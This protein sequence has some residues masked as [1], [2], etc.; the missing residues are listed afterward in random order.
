MH[1]AKARIPPDG[2]HWGLTAAVQE[3]NHECAS[4]ITNPLGCAPT[5]GFL[6]PTVEPET[7]P[8]RE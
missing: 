3:S 1:R 7:K 8:K 6:N 2:I 4:L 5:A